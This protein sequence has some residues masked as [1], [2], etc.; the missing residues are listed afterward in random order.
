MKIYITSIKEA[1]SEFDFNQ[2]INYI[3]HKKGKKL[4]GYTH[5]NSAWSSLIA[6]LLVRSIIIRQ[7]NMKNKD[8]NFGYG[9]KGKPFLLN[10]EKIHFNISHSKDMVICGVSDTDIGVDIENTNRKSKNY[11]DIANRFFSRSE[12]NFVKTGSIQDFFKIWTLKESYVKAIG[13]GIT[14]PLKDF[15]VPLRD[16]YTTINGVKWFFKNYSYNDYC[17]SICSSYNNLPEHIYYKNI[18]IKEI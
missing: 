12:Y 16:D 6:D 7:S 8:I 1:R 15:S 14:I 10:D 11:L 4:K 18:E 9:D 13:T 3:D 17:I 2:L 5:I